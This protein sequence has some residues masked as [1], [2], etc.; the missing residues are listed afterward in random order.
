MTQRK[1]PAH[2]DRPNPTTT[3]A[4]TTNRN[5]ADLHINGHEPVGPLRAKLTSIGGPLKSLTV[6]APQNDPFRCDTPAGHRDGAWLANTLDRLGIG[7][8]RHLRGLHYILIGQPKPNGLPYTNTESDWRWLSENAAKCARWLEYI[9]FNRIIDQRNDEPVIKKWAPP[10]PEPYVSVDFDIFLPEAED[11]TP[12][13]RIDGFTGAQPYH[14][15][16][17]GEK[18]SLR[19]VL[20]DVANRYKADLYLPTG[21]ISDTQAYIMASSAADDGRPMVVFYFSDCDP[22]GW[23]MPISLSR[24]LQAL[25]ELMMAAENGFEFMVYRVTLTPEQVRPGGLTVDGLPSTPLKDTE[26]R[27]DKWIDATGVAQT[28]IDALAALQPDLLEQIATDAIKPFYDST[29]ERRVAAARQQWLAVAQEAVDEDDGDDLEALR[30]TAVERIEEKREELQAIMDTVRV[31]ADAYDLP[32]PEVPEAVL[33]D[34]IPDTALCDSL[35]DFTE[36][37]ER[38]IASKSYDADDISGW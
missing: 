12:H 21:E 3:T 28:E 6:L 24:K 13:V 19:P 22:A 31:D 30:E 7:G 29:L 11:L 10:N 18:S 38:L 34:E 2:H 35:W 17:V 5:G 32:D 15:V 16:L 33:D 26:R 27:A 1:G 36:Q 37:C 25:Q 23:Q 4:A 20:G 14:L 9:P 8:Q